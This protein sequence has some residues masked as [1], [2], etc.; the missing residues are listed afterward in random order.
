MGRKPCFA[1]GVQP[2]IQL[3]EGNI[4]IPGGQHKSLAV[5]CAQTADQRFQFG[6][7]DHVA[8]VDDNDVGF[9]DLCAPYARIFRA[10]GAGR[11][12]GIPAQI[13]GVG[14]GDDQ[15]GRDEIAPGRSA[16]P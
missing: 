9:P 10:G 2:C 12:T 1:V 11:K 4:A 3:R 5:Q 13:K 15:A 8:F 14:H 16:L 6:R 7:R